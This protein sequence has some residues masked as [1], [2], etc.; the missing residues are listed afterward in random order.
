MTMEKKIRSL[1][2]LILAG[3]VLALS[4]GF[5]AGKKQ[6]FPK[7]KTVTWLV[8]PV[9]HGNG[10]QP[11]STWRDWNSY[12]ADQFPFRDFFVGAKPE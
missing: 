5:M 9:Y 12:L 7:M 10:R 8:F 11:E 6:V 2:A 4:A 3:L 1:T